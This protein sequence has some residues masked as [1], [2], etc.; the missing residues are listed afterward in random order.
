M[1]VP[2]SR[3]VYA[4]AGA[5]R[6][7]ELPRA[8][9]HALSVAIAL[10]AAGKPACPPGT[11][12]GSEIVASH[13]S[14]A[15]IHGLDL[16]GSM[17]DGTVT[18]TRRRDAA[19]SRSM[20]RPGVRLHVASLPECHV[21]TVRGLPVTS[22]ART[23]IDLARC[24]PLRDGVVVADSALRRGLATK[25]S[26]RA[27][28]ADCA[29]WPG[30]AR[31]RQVVAFSD[32]GSESA[33][34]SIGRVAFSEH[35]LPPPELQVWVGGEDEGRIGR[36]DFFWRQH[37]TIAEADGAFKYDNRGTAIAQLR[38][39]ARL[40]EAGFE[41]IHFTWSEITIAPAQVVSSI[42]AAFARAGK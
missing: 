29:C 37:R 21:V 41:V 32:A 13:Q 24:L 2:L 16:L 5:A 7:S 42:R 34:E 40:R 30:I 35:G 17:P 26:L 36:A 22:A 19:G 18:L 6:A 31:A 27:V 15:V 39:D 4:K 3:G 33:L 9:A 25:A 28:L 38:R 23:V 8:D 10:A 11:C 20:A 1:I 14:A 12:P